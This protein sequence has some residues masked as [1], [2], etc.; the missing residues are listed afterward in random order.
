M[1]LKN[2]SFLICL[3]TTLGLP[4]DQPTTLPPTTA[5]DP[6]IALVLTASTSSVKVGQPIRVSYR[7]ENR[8]TVP[9]YIPEMIG[10]VSD[11]R[12]YVQILVTAPKGADAIVSSRALD[13]SPDYWRDRDIVAEAK[14]KWVLLMP[15]HSYGR[16]DIVPFQPRTAGKYI[17]VAIHHPAHLSDAERQ[18]LTKSLDFP[19]VTKVTRSQPVI[20]LVKR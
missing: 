12:G 19:F 3:A 7:I 20:I 14:C 11:S 8:G 16:T 15:K 6:E 5:P 10:L 18:L 9:V 1:N 2:A 13:Y 17:L 4:I